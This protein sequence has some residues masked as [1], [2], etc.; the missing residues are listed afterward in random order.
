MM[1]RIRDDSHKKCSVLSL[2]CEECL[3]LLFLTT[4]FGVL[5][6]SRMSYIGRKTKLYFILLKKTLIVIFQYFPSHQNHWC[7]SPHGI[8]LAEYM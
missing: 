1:Q 5:L 4:I 8:K 2:G 7:K 3:D 6:L